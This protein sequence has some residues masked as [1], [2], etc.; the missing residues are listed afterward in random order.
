MACAVWEDRAFC[1]I[2]DRRPIPFKHDLQMVLAERLLGTRRFGFNHPSAPHR[3]KNTNR[4]SESFVAWI[5]GLT[6]H[7]ANLAC[8]QAGECRSATTVRAGFDRTEIMSA[9]SSRLYPYTTFLT[10]DQAQQLATALA[11][12]TVTQKTLAE[13]IP[14]AAGLTPCLIRRIRSR[15]R[16]EMR[17]AVK[18]K[19]EQCPRCA[20]PATCGVLGQTGIK[21]MIVFESK[22]KFGFSVYSA[23]KGDWAAKPHAFFSSR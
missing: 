14:E 20:E 23:S 18:E 21:R 19:V 1:R 12:Y 6:G 2:P 9:P 11:H 16:V 3:A 10:N 5:V 17:V 15:N 4:A 22:A 8:P 7:A 13:A